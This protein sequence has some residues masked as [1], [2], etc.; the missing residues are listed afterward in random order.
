[1]ELSAKGNGKNHVEDL[2][3]CQKELLQEKSR[4]TK[5][6]SDLKQ[7]KNEL[8]HQLMEIENKHMQV[9]ETRNKGLD[10]L[11][12]AQHKVEQSQSQCNSL[13]TIHKDRRTIIDQLSSETRQQKALKQQNVMQ[14]LNI[15]A[16]MA[17]RLRYEK[18]AHKRESLNQKCCEV[19]KLKIELEKEVR[20]QDQEKMDLETMLLTL[21]KETR[22][23]LEIPL[24]QQLSVFNM[25][26][27][28]NS[29]ANANLVLIE[30]SEAN[31]AIS[32]Q[33]RSLHN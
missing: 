32:L 33:V 4:L 25:F 8:D 19:E 14:F 1:M 29:A 21:Q 27:D 12:I 2:V 28:E 17:D 3:K 24:E 23:D 13:E 16:E 22:D 5:K 11:K 15:L 6:L 7:K 20:Q 30:Q 31:Q 10:T 9:M 26:K 18:D